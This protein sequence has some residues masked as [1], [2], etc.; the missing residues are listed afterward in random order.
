MH[1]RVAVQ[2]EEVAVEEEVSEER[3]LQVPCV[4]CECLC[5][6]VCMLTSDPCIPCVYHMSI[7]PPAIPI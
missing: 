6:C 7:V 5:L 3:F 1:T 4:V 2:V